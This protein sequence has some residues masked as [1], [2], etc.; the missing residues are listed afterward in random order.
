VTA[1]I[2]E[3]MQSDEP[4]HPDLVE[5]VIPT[6]FGSVVHHPLVIEIAPHPGL[7][8]ARYVAKTQQ[9]RSA[10]RRKDWRSFVWLHERP[11]RLNAFVDIHRRLDDD[12]Y[13][14]LLADIWIDSE[15]IWQNTAEWIL[16][17]EA[18]RAGSMMSPEEA[19]ALESMPDPVTVYRGAIADRNEEGLSWTVDRERAEWFAT[20]MASDGDV[21]VVLEGRVDRDL[22][23]AYL[24]GRGEDEVVV[25]DWAFVDVVGRH[26]PAA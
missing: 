21:A 3:L 5:H 26:T 13:W 18:D 10:R 24:T 9:V 15:N 25:F 23:A 22:V 16:L 8:N 7:V 1:N 14:S 12:A 17:L 4:L 6:E 19:E 11:Y 20:R 2:I